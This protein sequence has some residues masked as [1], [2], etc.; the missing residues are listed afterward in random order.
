MNWS[1][2][3]CA[4][5][6]VAWL[7]ILV[8]TRNTT[9]G[10]QKQTLHRIVASSHLADWIPRARSTHPF[11]ALPLLAPT[12]SPDSTWAA[13]GWA[14][15]YTAK[16]I[17]DFPGWRSRVAFALTYASISSGPNPSSANTQHAG[18]TPLVNASAARRAGLNFGTRFVP[19]ILPTLPT[20][21]IAIRFSRCL[22][23]AARPETVLYAIVLDSCRPTSFSKSPCRCA[24]F[25]FNMPASDNVF[26][27]ISNYHV[28]NKSCSFRF[29]KRAPLRLQCLLH[30]LD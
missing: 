28:T 16:R 29:C 20:S 14:S 30:V 1:D 9:V 10:S 5:G 7:Q 8:S 27:W 18:R 6:A 17:L 25:K 4:S 13:F 24:N 26:G 3:G 21:L 12:H 23:R 15:S 19:L 22:T 2:G 11:Y